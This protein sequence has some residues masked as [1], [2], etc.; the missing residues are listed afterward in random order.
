VERGMERG[1]IS[2]PNSLSPPN[3]HH[4]G[5][6]LE[7]EVEIPSGD[8]SIPVQIFRCPDCKRLRFFSIQHD[9]LKPWP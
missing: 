1:I 3:C 8:A 6:V 9:G 5:G 2:P 4:C 7:F